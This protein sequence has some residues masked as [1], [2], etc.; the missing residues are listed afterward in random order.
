MLARAK[1]I[2]AILF[3][4]LA[5]IVAMPR[6]A[7]ALETTAEFA[8]L[9]DYETGAVLWGKNADEQMYPSSMS[10]LMTLEMLFNALR[11][12]T[13]SLEDEFRI[14]EYAWR[15]G[16]AASGSST[17]FA[18]L[19][20]NVPVEAI[21]RSIV[22]Q[23][24]NDA[25]IA[26]AEALSGSESAFAEAMNERAKELGM[27]NSHFV[28]STG[29]P[30]PEHVMTAYDLGLLARHLIM[31]FPEYYPIFKETEFTWNGIRQANR[32][33]GLYLDP[34]IDGLK[35]G[36]TEAAGYG[37]VAS[38]KRGDQRLILVVN[39][40]PSEKARAD[41]TVKLMDWGFRSF[42]KYELFTAGAVVDNA[43]VWEGTYDQVPM[44][45]KNDINIIISPQQR[46]DM[47]VSVVYQSPIA[48]PVAPGQEIGTLKI[49]VPGI[50]VQEFP[51]VAGGAVERQGIFGRAMGALK[52]M[53]LGS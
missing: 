8:M 51:L 35:T 40:L 33:P 30:H 9:M 42:K 19:N 49:E 6:P 32:N 47:K 29:W 20:S 27:N 31:D 26:T 41:E 1:F 37:L 38:A 13:V 18:D 52:H 12:G 25:C 24:G 11:E 36:H 7:A 39:G 3:L 50:P 14:S 22:I 17:M 5:S 23:S 43:P 34:T 44:V 4:L 10:K 21:L 48:A 28:N 2:P 45:T 16:G 53:I 15:V 46:K